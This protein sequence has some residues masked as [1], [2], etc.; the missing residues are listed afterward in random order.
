[1]KDIDPILLEELAIKAIVRSTGVSEEEAAIFYGGKD[2]EGFL[3]EMVG[4][5]DEGLSPQ[6]AVSEVTKNW[7][8][9]QMQGPGDRT[10]RTYLHS[11]I[12]AAVAAAS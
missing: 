2:G 9:A 4:L 1:M 5:I 10:G 8:V 6:E 11:R 3:H 7:A 12:A